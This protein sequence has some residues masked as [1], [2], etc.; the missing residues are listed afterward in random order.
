MIIQVSD[1]RHHNDLCQ[2]HSTIFEPAIC[3]THY[4]EFW[5]PPSVSRV[6]KVQMANKGQILFH[7][8]AKYV[9]H[10]IFSLF[11]FRKLWYVWF[12]DYL[13][14]RVRPCTQRNLT[15]LV[16]CS[17]F[18]SA[19][20]LV[21]PHM[22]FPDN[23]TLFTRS[24]LFSWYLVSF[25][26]TLVPS[27]CHTDFIFQSASCFKLIF[28]FCLCYIHTRWKL[29]T[30]CAILCIFSHL[31]YKGL[32]LHIGFP[33]NCNDTCLISISSKYLILTNPLLSAPPILVFSHII[34]LSMFLVVTSRLRHRRT[35]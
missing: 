28:A 27:Y 5:V 12:T 10:I 19:C 9:Q 26:C 20:I 33:E 31:L 8:W 2:P 34:L 15:L 18:P 4:G 22:D 14:T 35:F 21:Y 25:S 3:I 16:F 11:Q 24:S 23:A 30:I 13:S 6:A 32:C 7:G 17:T 1:H 29:Q